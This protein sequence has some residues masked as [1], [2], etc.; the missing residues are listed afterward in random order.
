MIINAKAV[1]QNAFLL[2]LLLFLTFPAGSVNALKLGS[3]VL[4]ILILIFYGLLCKPTIKIRPSVV[5]VLC[6]LTSFVCFSLLLSFYFSKFEMHALLEFRSFI[7]MIVFV[8]MGFFLFDGESFEKYV[9]VFFVGIFCYAILKNSIIILIFL[10]IESGIVEA[11]VNGSG[12]NELGYVGGHGVSRLVSVNDFFL[13]F[14]YFL[15]DYFFVSRRARFLFKL[16]IIFTVFMSFTRLIWLYFF[17]MF[18]LD[19]LIKRSLGRNLVILSSAVLSVI[20]LSHNFSLDFFSSA[21]GRF[22]AEGLLSLDVKYIQSVYLIK[23]LNEYPLFGKGLGT[24]VEEYVRNESI[25]YAYEVFWLLLA[26]QFGLLGVV[27]FVFSLFSPFL[28]F[29]CSNRFVFSGGQILILS[30]FI[31]FLLAGFTNPILLNSVV[32]FWFLF[33]YF[34]FFSLCRPLRPRVGPNEV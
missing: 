34:S 14:T 8:F 1:S 18:L 15:V 9:R 19:I 26:L 4:I 7:L 3:F 31:L 12:F 21:S 30:S 16:V 33:L 11:L 13:V 2:V 32:A 17:A 10:N 5:L 29:S 28:Y 24:Y 23:E 22:G 20:F 6:F 27:I 25:P